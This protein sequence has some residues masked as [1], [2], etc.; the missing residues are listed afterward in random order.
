MRNSA[1]DPSST[2]TYRRRLCV[3]GMVAAGAFVAG[4]GGGPEEAVPG[5][6]S[7]VVIE[8]GDPAKAHLPAPAMRIEL[9]SDRSAFHPGDRI[10]VFCHLDA[11][12]GAAMPQRVE[13]RLLDRN[14]REMDN[15]VVDHHKGDG[16]GPVR[17]RAELTA[18]KQPGAYRIEAQAVDSVISRDSGSASAISHRITRSSAIKV[19]VK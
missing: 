11:P 2:K 18:P 15:C 12:E 10:G 19:T 9:V 5:S 17:L 6:G 7:S 13:I 4:C 3:V 16:A 8:R 1:Q 14:N